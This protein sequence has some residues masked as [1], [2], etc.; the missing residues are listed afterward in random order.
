MK[1]TALVI[2][3][4]ALVLAGVAAGASQTD[5]GQMM[6]RMMGPMMMGNYDR[7]AE[8]TIKGTVEKIEKPGIDH[9]R[10]MGG[11]H[12]AVK[13]EN[14]TYTVHLGPADFVEKTMTF[15]EGDAIEVTGSKMTMM[16]ETAL[17]AREVR[18]GD[19]VLKLRDENG[20]PLWPMQMHGRH[21]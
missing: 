18:K 15:K 6:G 10:G 21:S 2:G 20:M 17:M 1:R 16:G 9:M 12:L 4:T 3:L 14:E 11:I 8:M 7:A 5:H 19:T 13:T